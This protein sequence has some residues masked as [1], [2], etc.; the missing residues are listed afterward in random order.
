MAKE[1][2]KRPGRTPAQ[3]QNDIP[4][5]PEIHY[6]TKHGKVD[7]QTFTAGTAP[8]RENRVT[9]K[10]ISDVYPAIDTDLARD[11]VENDLTAADKQDLQ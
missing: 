3:P 1:D 4:P 9:D 6:E 10:P 5:V 2:M 7:A 8:R 11:N